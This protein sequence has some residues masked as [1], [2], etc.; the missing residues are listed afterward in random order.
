MLSISVLLEVERVVYVAAFDRR[1]SWSQLLAVV[2][3]TL[4]GP[5]VG[6][7]DVEFYMSD[8]VF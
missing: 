2:V 6:F 4:S 3:D 1:K 8:N 7:V 5:F